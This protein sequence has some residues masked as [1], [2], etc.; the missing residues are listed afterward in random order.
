MSDWFTSHQTLGLQE[1]FVQ[2][3][4]QCS[5]KKYYGDC[6]PK[7]GWLATQSTPPGSATDEQVSGVVLKSQ[8][9]TLKTKLWFHK[10]DMGLSSCMDKMWWQILVLDLSHFTLVSIRASWSSVTAW[11]PNLSSNLVSNDPEFWP[12][13]HARKGGNTG[14][15]HMAS[16][17]RQEPWH[18]S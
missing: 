6:K 2:V 3:N 5:N 10:I 4:S 16:A 13:H 7:G 12:S 15:A 8:T 17:M 14:L 11:S 18:S 1:W 9:L